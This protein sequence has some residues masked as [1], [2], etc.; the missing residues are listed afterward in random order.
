MN[1]QYTELKFH[2]VSA[3]ILSKFDILS[4]CLTYNIIAA[5][6]AHYCQLWSQKIISNIF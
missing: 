1:M 4:A 5:K 3:L 2:F 6:I